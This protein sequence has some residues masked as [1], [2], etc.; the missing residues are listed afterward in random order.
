MNIFLLGEFID[1]YL[2]GLPNET[3]DDRQNKLEARLR[4]EDFEKWVKIEE[5][6]YL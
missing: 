6:N 5:G 1:S 3:D 2:L 4:L